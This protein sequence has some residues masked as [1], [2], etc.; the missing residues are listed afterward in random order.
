MG[1]SSLVPR[2]TPLSVARWMQ[3]GWY[4]VQHVK[5]GELNKHKRINYL[6][7]YRNHSINL[8]NELMLL[9]LK[10]RISSVAVS[11]SWILINEQ[12][13]SLH[14]FQRKWFKLLFP[15]E[16]ALK[17]NLEPSNWKWTNTDSILN[18]EHTEQVENYIWQHLITMVL[19]KV[20]I[21]PPKPTEEEPSFR[22]VSLLPAKLRLLFWVRKF[23]H[24]LL[25]LTDPG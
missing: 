22:K 24:N 14:N 5:T 10:I 17:H 3:R 12:H 20:Q 9:L 4:L 15:L 23:C 8:I 21:H 13:Q 19:K 16:N 18:N 2:P 1:F 11:E 7:V 25:P 6:H